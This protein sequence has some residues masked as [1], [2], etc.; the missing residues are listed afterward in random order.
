MVSFA[1]TKSAMQNFM[2]EGGGIKKVWLKFEIVQGVWPTST[3]GGLRPNPLDD[4][5]PGRGSENPM[6]ENWGPG[7]WG[8][9]RQAANTIASCFLWE[10]FPLTL[11]WIRHA[12][13]IGDTYPDTWGRGAYPAFYFPFLILTG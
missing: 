3:E 9:V 10:H 4:S 12:T 1:S 7:W 11:E 6:A 5:E 13:A 8:K 2:V